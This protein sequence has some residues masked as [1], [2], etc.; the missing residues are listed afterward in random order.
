MV[1]EDGSN[2]VCRGD[3]EGHGSTF[4]ASSFSESA[5][6]RLENQGNAK[7]CNFRRCANFLNSQ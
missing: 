2:G 6:Q 5:E 4:I 7:F 3:T 1:A